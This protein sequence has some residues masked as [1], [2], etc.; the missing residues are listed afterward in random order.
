MHA[1]ALKIPVKIV[2]GWHN[3]ANTAQCTYTRK[4]R[5]DISIHTY[6][7]FA[8]KRWCTVQHNE[9]TILINYR[10]SR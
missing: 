4:Q 7:Q 2:L 9:E 3:T 6:N 10:R 8:S 1:K 5:K